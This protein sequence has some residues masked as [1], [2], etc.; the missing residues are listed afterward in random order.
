MMRHFITVAACGHVR[1]MR[2]AVLGCWLCWA[3]MAAALAADNASDSGSSAAPIGHVSPATA[4][5]VAAPGRSAW[6]ADFSESLVAV[7]GEWV[8][9]DAVFGVTWLQVGFGAGVLALV[10]LADQFLRRRLRQGAGRRA[11]AV[12]GRL[13]AAWLEL[14]VNATLAPL[15]WFLWLWGGHLALSVWLAGLTGGNAAWVIDALHW[16]YHAGSL[17]VLFWFLFRMI[18]VA[19]MLLKQWAATTAS[20][21]DAVLATVASRA[22]LFVA[23]L[24]AV[25]FV[26]PTLDIPQ[27]HRQL[28]RDGTSLLLILAIGFTLY[29]LVHALSEAVLN[30]YRVEASDN[31][32]A[33]KVHTQVKVLKKVAIILIGFFTAASML[34]VFDSVRQLGTSLLASAGIAGIICGFA[35]Q[36]SIATLLAGF[37]IA[38]TQPIRLD[39]AVVVE[40]E[41]GRIEEITLTYVVVCLWDLRRLI[42][43]INYFIEKQFQNWTRVNADLLGS[44]VLQV[45]YTTPLAV[46]RQEYERIL[47]NSPLWDGKAKGLQV[48]DAKEHT[49]EVRALV[50]AADAS[51]TW[52]LR[53]EVR[54]K[55]VDFL[56]R[57][58]PHCLPR[59]RTESRAQDGQHQRNDAPK[60][61]TLAHSGRHLIHRR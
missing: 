61:R 45:D 48:T 43:P 31:L 10:G 60:P 41:F 16:L 22:L 55:L 14:S 57:E 19:E 27:S 40:N 4:G 49:L 8:K 23:P 47:K 42:V 36:R 39:D 2:M 59:T 21:W 5:T 24:V 56:Q 29:Q 34:M 44:V 25:I 1:K 51:A 30:L 13:R 58:H 20:K 12:G 11:A 35:A 15:A 50:S 18:K 52:D 17:V 7:V 54:E 37:Q 46:L 38:I 3:G 28:F 53:C 6:R 26:L 9:R 32:E 33:R